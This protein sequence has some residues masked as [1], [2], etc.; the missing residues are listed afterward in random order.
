[1]IHCSTS[2]SDSL[3][4]ST[5]GAPIFHAADY[6]LVADLNKAILDETEKFV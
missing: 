1:M 6:G 4:A 2:F 5:V 3:S